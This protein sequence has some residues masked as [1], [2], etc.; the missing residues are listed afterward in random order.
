MPKDWD[1]IVKA[2]AQRNATSAEWDAEI[3]RQCQSSSDKRSYGEWSMKDNFE[4]LRFELTPL[5]TDFLVENLP[6]INFYATQN[7]VYKDWFAKMKHTVQRII[8]LG[9]TSKAFYALR[10][11]PR[12]LRPDNEDQDEDESQKSTDSEDDEHGFVFHQLGILEAAKRTPEVGSD[13]AKRTSRSTGFFVVARITN[14]GGAWGLYIIFDKFPTDEDEGT[15]AE[16]P[17]EEVGLLPHENL[18]ISMARLSGSP[19]LNYRSF[20]TQIQ[21]LE[22]FNFPVELV[23]ARK[24][25]SGDGLV[26]LT[27]YEG[28]EGDMAMRGY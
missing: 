24:T 18:Q 20:N 14:S 28:F 16:S 5:S 19:L 3:D 6:R 9:C 25:A 10:P 13:P 7:S 22:T 4:R 8:P 11:A 27:V 12:G 21:W 23:F 15:R 26:R 1:A 17:E 2:L